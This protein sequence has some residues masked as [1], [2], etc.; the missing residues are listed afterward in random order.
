MDAH[1]TFCVAGSD[2]TSCLALFSCQLGP[3]LGSPSP[4]RVAASLFWMGIIRLNGYV[5]TFGV[6][7]IRASMLLR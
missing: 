2:D 5:E 1:G 4:A 3:A 6:E 7:L